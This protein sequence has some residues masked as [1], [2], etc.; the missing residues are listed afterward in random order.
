MFVE[1]I[2]YTDEWYL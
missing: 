2:D 1:S